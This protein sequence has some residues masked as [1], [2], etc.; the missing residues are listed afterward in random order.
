MACG[1]LDYW[2]LDDTRLLGIMR[3]LMLIKLENLNKSAF[4]ILIPQ[5]EIL[6]L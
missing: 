2:R 3:A 4:V 6:G 5:N 1:F